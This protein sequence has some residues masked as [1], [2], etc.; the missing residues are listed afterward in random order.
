MASPHNGH[1]A[2]IDR[3][4]YVRRGL[5]GLTEAEERCAHEILFRMQ[6]LLSLGTLTFN[7]TCRANL[8]TKHPIVL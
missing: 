3:I 8:L 2:A 5:T 6:Y 7:E 4:E 1:E